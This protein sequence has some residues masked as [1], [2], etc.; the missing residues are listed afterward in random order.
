MK[1]PL[2]AA[3]LM[4]LLMSGCAA[5]Y[6]TVNGM[7]YCKDCRKTV[8]V[9]GKK[10]KVKLPSVGAGGVTVDL[11]ELENQETYA[12][13]SKTLGLVNQALVACCNFQ[14]AAARANDRQ[15]YD[16]WGKVAQ[17][18]VEKLQQLQQIVATQEGATPPQVAA[19][20]SAEGSTTAAASGQKKPATA[21]SG[22][23]KGKAVGKW[24]GAYAPKNATAK[25]K[26]PA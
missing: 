22:K 2:L 20:A 13:A 16:R 18:Q 3:L 21:G 4:T 9:V 25:L 6:T 1:L 14:N 11:G 8:V 7:G 5:D 26:L 17:E 24:A 12:D 10:Q 19:T 23:K 15:S